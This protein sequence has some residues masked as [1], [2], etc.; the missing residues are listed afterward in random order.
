MRLFYHLIFYNYT[1]YVT[2]GSVVFLMS[3]SLITM[4]LHISRYWFGFTSAIY[5]IYNTVL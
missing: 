3:K 1:N 5:K 2:L 4:L